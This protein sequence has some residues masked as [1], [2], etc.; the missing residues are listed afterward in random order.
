MR[1]PWKA[2]APLEPGHEYLVLAS[3][4]PGRQWR[5]TRKL[6][7]GSSAV[8]KQLAGADGL[9]GFSMEAKPIAKQYATLSVWR[10]AAALDNFVTANPH[11]EIMGDLK[12]EMGP[13]KFVRWT[14]DGRDGRPNWNDARS[15][16]AAP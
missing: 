14:I 8:R 15:R 4:I 9:V 3:S 2:I 6:F 1:S 11:R 5:S 10:D 12:P 13:T 16:L 7:R